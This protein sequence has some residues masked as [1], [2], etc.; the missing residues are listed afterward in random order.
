[1]RFGNHK[2]EMRAITFSGTG[3]ARAIYGKKAKVEI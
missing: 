2:K 1:M 3:I